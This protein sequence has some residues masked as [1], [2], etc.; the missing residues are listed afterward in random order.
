MKLEPGVE[1]VDFIVPV[2][3][4]PTL[5]VDLAC[6]IGTSEVLDND[7]RPSQRESIWLCRSTFSKFSFPMLL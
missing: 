7:S 4:R 2:V 1:L 6:F 3:A 5:D